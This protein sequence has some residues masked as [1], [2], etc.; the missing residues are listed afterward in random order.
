LL[1]ELWGNAEETGST[2]HR[3]FSLLADEGYE[4]HWWDTDHLRRWKAAD[5]AVTCF[6]L[7]DSHRSAL[8]A[9]GVSSTP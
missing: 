9:R 8:A 7:A 4:P 5:R 2:A 3:L 6:F 1:L